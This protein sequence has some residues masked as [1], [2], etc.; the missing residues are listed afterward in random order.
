VGSRI[1]VIDQGQYDIGANILKPVYGAVLAGSVE[2]DS[3][4]AQSVAMNYGF[5]LMK[6]GELE[7]AWQVLT[8]VKDIYKAGRSPSA[9]DVAQVDIKLAECA[10]RD[11]RLQEARDL[12]IEAMRAFEFLTIEHP[13]RVFGSVLAAQ[14]FHAGGH[15]EEKQYLFDTHINP[16]LETNT[17]AS[18]QLRKFLDANPELYPSGPAEALLRMMRFNQ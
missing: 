9:I 13:L 12:A 4:E 1:Q 2:R 7:T 18:E 5:C 14:C 6:A 16:L 11:D 8:D 15:T 3:D 17:G 10:L